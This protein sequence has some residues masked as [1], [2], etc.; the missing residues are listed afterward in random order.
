[1]PQGGM[2]L[3]L[4]LP[5]HIDSEELIVRTMKRKVVF[6]PGRSFFTTKT[7]QRHVRMNFSNA[8]EMEIE[9]GI[10]V[11]SEEINR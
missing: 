6:V 9:K 11:I 4:T 7:G 1:M 2:F 5:E 8:C 10:K 3:W